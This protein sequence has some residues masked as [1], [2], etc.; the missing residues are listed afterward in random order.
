[1]SAHAVHSK[2]N[3]YEILVTP[4]ESTVEMALHLETAIVGSVHVTASPHPSGLPADFNLKS[5]NY[6]GLAPADSIV[7]QL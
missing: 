7:F 6:S 1:M 2:G 3:Q 5:L 4:I